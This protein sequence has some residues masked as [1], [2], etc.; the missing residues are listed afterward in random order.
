MKKNIIIITPTNEKNDNLFTVYP[1]I[2]F[3]PDWYRLSPSEEP[4]TK[5]ELNTR[6]V[7]ST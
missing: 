6:L 4:G 7:R 1:A 5:S 2:D 3:I